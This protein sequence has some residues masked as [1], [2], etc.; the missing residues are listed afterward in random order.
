MLLCP[1]TLER[2]RR[3][4]CTRAH[5]ERTDEALLMVCWECGGVSVRHSP[6]TVCVECVLV[7]ADSPDE[8]A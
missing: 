5:C 8:G 6:L 7:H 4:A 2:C 3:A 1:E